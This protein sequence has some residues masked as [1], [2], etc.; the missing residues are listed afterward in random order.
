MEKDLP[1]KR[2]DVYLLTPTAYADTN[3]KQFIDHSA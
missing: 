2:F 3:L 1:P